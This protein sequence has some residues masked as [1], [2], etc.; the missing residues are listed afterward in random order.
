MLSF[1]ALS[2]PRNYINERFH[3][4]F[5]FQRF[6]SHSLLLLHSRKDRT[7]SRRNC[8]N[9]A[10]VYELPCRW[11]YRVRTKG[12]KRSRVNSESCLKFENSSMQA[13]RFS[14]MEVS[15]DKFW[16]KYSYREELICDKFLDSLRLSNFNDLETG[17]WSCTDNLTGTGWQETREYLLL[18][19]VKRVRVHVMALPDWRHIEV[20]IPFPHFSFHLVHTSPRFCQGSCNRQLWRHQPT[21]FEEASAQGFVNLW[22]HSQALPFIYIH[23]YIHISNDYPSLTLP[24]TCTCAR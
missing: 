18:E 23:T 8:G 1:S 15:S 2:R 21:D 24:G 5:A 22:L 10:S 7:S 14:L 19:A 6:L 13:H 12:E 17:T 9:G 20:Y 3:S 11:F 16:V 4:F